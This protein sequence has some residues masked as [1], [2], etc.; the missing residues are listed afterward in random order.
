LEAEQVS[1]PALGRRLES[2]MNG[3]KPADSQATDPSENNSSE[4]TT[5]QPLAGPGV[6]SLLQGSKRTKNVFAEPTPSR[7]VKIEPPKS[8]AVLPAPRK[9]LIPRWYFFAADVALIGFALLVVARSSGP[10]AWR[11]VTFCIAAVVVGA[12]LAAIGISQP[13][14]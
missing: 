6:S 8:E 7:S 13:N 3:A 5:E 4:Q 14:D 12:I 9:R 10:L 1:K 2:L 11:E